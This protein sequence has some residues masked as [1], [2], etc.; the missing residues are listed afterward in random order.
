M[1]NIT[2]LKILATGSSGNCYL[3]QNGTET[4][5]IEAGIPY[6]RILKGLDF[7]LM[8]VVGVVISHS[9]QDHSKSAEDFKR[10]G[11]PVFDSYDSEAEKQ[12]R[13]YGNFIIHS[14]KLEHDVPCMGFYILHPDM[15]SLVYLTDTE[16]CK[17]RFLNVN[18][19]LIEANYDAR[20]I[21]EDH[22]ARVHILKGH[23]EL[24]TTKGFV[25]A[26]KS[27][28][29]R[30]VVLCHMSVENMDETVMQKEISKVAGKRVKV[31]MA[32]SGLCVEL[33]KFP[34]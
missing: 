34:F 8:N 25:R 13:T 5:I 28:E 19:I 15:G 31:S 22:P 2:T 17:Y 33:S 6:K 14:F 18:H 7:N 26:N 23:M 1:S 16:Y 29:L 9:H 11:I 30:N 27:R 32:E 12:V 4:L 20:L 10:A 24:Q 21:P 3:L